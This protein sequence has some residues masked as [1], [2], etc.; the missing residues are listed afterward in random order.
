MRRGL[1]E[2]NELL[3]DLIQC[4]SLMELDTFMRDHLA[5]HSGVSYDGKF[6]YKQYSKE[7]KEEAVALVTEQGYFAPKACPVPLDQSTFL[8][9]LSRV[10][11]T[12]VYNEIEKDCQLS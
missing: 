10:M 7:F 9:L 8:K 5:N 3:Q 2:G 6:S 11:R 4:P 1:S 12:F